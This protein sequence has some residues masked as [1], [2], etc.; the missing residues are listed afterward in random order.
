MPCSRTIRLPSRPPSRTFSGTPERSA[1]A[2]ETSASCRARCTCEDMS[3]PVA[4][5]RTSH[6]TSSTRPPA[7]RTSTVRPTSTPHPR[8][9][10]VASMRASRVMHRCPDSGCEGSQPVSRA[11]PA[12]A[13]RTTSPRPA[14]PCCGGSTAIVMSACPES[15]GVMTGPSP[16]A[17]PS[18]SAS[19]K[20]SGAPGMSSCAL[21][22]PLVSAAAFPRLRS[23][24][25]SSTPPAHSATW[26]VWSTEP[27]ST[28]TIAPT[29]GS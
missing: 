3:R 4:R 25:T 14:A 20:S 21:A 17:D 12:L 1:R 2:S 19:T 8:A 13:V 27:S 15:T 9:S 10:G 6:G 24:R 22:A 23:C 29:A 26:A 5:C 7:R 18:R 28:T 16:A 11:M